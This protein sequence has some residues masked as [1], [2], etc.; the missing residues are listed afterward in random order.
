MSLPI[1]LALGLVLSLGIALV[2]C[3]QR[4]LTRSGVAGAVL[5]GTLTLGCGGWA[6]GLALIAFFVSSNLFTRWRRERKATL[7]GTFAKGGRRDLFQALANGGVGTILA[8]L[9]AA[10][11]RPAWAAAFVGALAAATADT[12]ATEVGVLSPTPPRLITTGK[13]VPAGTS[14]GITLQGNLA[15]AGGALFLG[16]CFYLLTLAESAI[17]AAMEVQAGPGRGARSTACSGPPSRA[18]T[19]VHAA[20]RRRSTAS[21]AAGRP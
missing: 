21:T 6:W 20:G 17:G 8:V 9:A 4:S 11:P 19:A 3:R 14:G 5:T 15:A 13:Q 18:S 10:L 1:R 16:T 2:A 7:A 12:W